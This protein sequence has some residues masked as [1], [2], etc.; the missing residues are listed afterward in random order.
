[1]LRNSLYDFFVLYVPN[2]NTTFPILLLLFYKSP[3]KILD[4]QQDSCYQIN[5]IKGIIFYKNIHRFYY[6]QIDI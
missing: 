3:V 5:K 2:Q 6:T 1:M 4:S